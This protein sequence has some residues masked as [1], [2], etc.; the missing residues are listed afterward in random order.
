MLGV[1]GSGGLFRVFVLVGVL[2]V[3]WWVWWDSGF[4]VCWFVG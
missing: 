2:A 1:A 4:L 3:L